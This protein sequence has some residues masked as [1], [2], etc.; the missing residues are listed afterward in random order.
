MN[1]RK[2]MKNNMKF[3]IILRTLFN[4]NENIKNVLNFIKTLEFIRKNEF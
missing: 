1:E 4:T 3:F 2:E